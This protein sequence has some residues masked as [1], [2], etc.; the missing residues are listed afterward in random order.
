MLKGPLRGLLPFIRVCE[1]FA[2]HMHD[3]LQGGLE[4][5][6]LQ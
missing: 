5:I 1:V 4:S 3:R 6:G 2:K